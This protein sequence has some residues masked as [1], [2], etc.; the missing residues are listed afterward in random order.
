ML[1]IVFV[2]FLVI[3]L[4]VHVLKGLMR[5]GGHLSRDYTRSGNGRTPRVK[6]QGLSL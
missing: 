3:S 1:S 6:D 5:K 4:L 2:F